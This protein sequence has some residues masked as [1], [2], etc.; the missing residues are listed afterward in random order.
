LKQLA[1][2]MQDSLPKIK[3]L[4]GKVH[5]QNVR[6]GKVNCKCAKGELHKAFYRFWSH[7]GKVKKAYVRKADVERVRAGCKLWAEMNRTKTAMLRSPDADRVRREIRA[8]LRSAGAPDKIIRR[9]TR[10]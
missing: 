8:M 10:R 3:A 9:L 7:R 2:D 1:T 6:C 5:I 4:P